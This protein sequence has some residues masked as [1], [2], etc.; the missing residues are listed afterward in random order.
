MN[1]DK[2]ELIEVMTTS[3]PRT[4]QVLM[5][6]TQIRENIVGDRYVTLDP[7]ERIVGVVSGQ[8]I[9]MA[10]V[11]LGEDK[12]VEDLRR[13]KEEATEVLNRWDECA[14]LVPVQLGE[15]KSDAVK[16]VLIDLLRDRGML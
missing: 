8:H 7:G 6:V 11:S 4:R 13:W 16:R 12:E 14:E 10:W 9:D 5:R 15:L 2:E 1:L 3:F